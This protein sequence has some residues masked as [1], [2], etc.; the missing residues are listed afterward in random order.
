M[1]LIKTLLNS[2]GYTGIVVTTIKDKQETTRITSNGIYM[3]ATYGNYYPAY[4]GGFYD[5]YSN[6]YASGY[7]YGGFGGYI[8][9]STSKQTS[10]TYVLETVAYNLDAPQENQIVSVI[11]S[12]IKN[13][14]DADKTAAEFVK[15]IMQSLED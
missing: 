10:T 3:G 14:N 6:P 8:P 4:Y 7:Y 1:Y 12:E 9:M 13:P 5:Y 15:K 11:T 2:E